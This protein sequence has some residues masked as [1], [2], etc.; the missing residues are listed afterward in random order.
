M[1]KQQFAAMVIEQ[2]KTLYRVA[3]SMLCN[4]YDCQDAMQEAITKAW[5]KKILTPRGK[6]FFYMAYSH[7]H[8]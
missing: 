8:K 5:E 3:R 4:S 7:T 6:V 1:D 2:E